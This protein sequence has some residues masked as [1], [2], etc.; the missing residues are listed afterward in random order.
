MALLLKV[1]WTDMKQK[2]YSE[3]QYL[4]HVDAACLVVV[5]QRSLS[6]TAS[7]QFFLLFCLHALLLQES[8]FQLWLGKKIKII[9]ERGNDSQQTK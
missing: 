4:D 5:V 2:Q 1:K 8:T 9:L 7:P 6:L 3:E